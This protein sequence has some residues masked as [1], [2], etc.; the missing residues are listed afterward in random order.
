MFGGFR[1]GVKNVGTEVLGF[2]LE[3]KVRVYVFVLLRFDYRAQKKR[4]HIAFH[5]G[6]CTSLPFLFFPLSCFPFFFGE[7][8]TK[9][10][11]FFPHGKDLSLDPSNK[12]F[13]WMLPPTLD[14]QSPQNKKKV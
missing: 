10:Q 9:H 14:I 4:G 12:L 13:F 2:L 7:K 5:H 8:H 11:H 3:V 1:L 6:Y